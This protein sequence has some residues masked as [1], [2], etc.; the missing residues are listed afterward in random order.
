MESLCK[1]AGRGGLSGMDA[2]RAAMGQGWPFAACP[3]NND[4]A[5]EVWRRSRQ[6]RMPG[7]LSLWLL[8]LCANKEKVTRREGEK[9]GCN[10]LAAT[11]KQFFTLIFIRKFMPINFD[12]VIESPDYE[13]DMKAGLETLQGVSD[14]TRTIGETLLLGKVPERISS[15]SSVRTTLKKTFKGSYGQSFR[16]DVLD[17]ESKKELRKIGQA[18]FVELMSYFM[19][20]ALYIETPDPSEKAQAVLNRLGDTSEELIKQL[21]KPAM[22]NI[23]E[24]SVKFDYDVS[25]R[26]RKSLEDR[27]P[28][29][30][31]TKESVH[32]VLATRRDEKLDLIASIR[33]FNT[34]TGNGR[35]QLKG[36]DETVAFGFRINYRDI[37]FAMKKKF[38]ANLDS[39]NGIDNEHWK[40]LTLVAN[41]IR[42]Q[43]GVIVKETL[44][45]SSPA[46]HLGTIR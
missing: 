17:E 16:L 31:F 27:I 12:I 24:I 41:P 21:R 40:Y 2:A 44:I 9:S 26:Y 7:A 35:L 37:D 34:N 15:K 23:H 6:T 36:E 18:T 19:K 43:D 14:A 8:S 13:V 11:M 25:V 1:W 45:Y 42:R 33:R 20:E 38:T 28:L 22:E 46:T 29:A 4:G 10:H 5:K 30:K 39:N 32:A 3:W